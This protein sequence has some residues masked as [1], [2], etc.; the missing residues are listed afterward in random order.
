[1]DTKDE[2][3]RVYQWRVLWALQLINTMIQL[4]QEWPWK[5]TEKE[6][7]LSK[8]NLAAHLLGHFIG[9]ERWP[10]LSVYTYSWVVADGLASWLVTKTFG[11]ERCRTLGMAPECENLSVIGGPRKALPLHG[12]FFTIRRENQPRVGL[13]INPLPQAS[14]CLPSRNSGHAWT[15]PSHDT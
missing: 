1:M 13:S 14:H 12:E 6:S 7:W 3:S 5:K 2:D 9:K 8:H 4:T 15:W 10:D 11:E